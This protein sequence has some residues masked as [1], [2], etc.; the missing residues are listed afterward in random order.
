MVQ[1]ISS[2]VL[3]ILYFISTSDVLS[4]FLYSL[5]DDIAITGDDEERDHVIKKEF[6][7]LK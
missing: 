6:K 4:L 7:D 2:V 5:F 1:D 3:I